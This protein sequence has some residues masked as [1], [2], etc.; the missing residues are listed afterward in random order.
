MPGPTRSQNTQVE[1]LV[2]A[3]L[4]QLGIVFETNAPDIAGKP[5]IVFR[6]QRAVVFVHGC[7]WH[8]H[9]CHLF[10]WPVK[11]PEFWRNKI[12]ATKIRD[13]AVALALT[14]DRWRVLEVWE[15]ALRGKERFPPDDVAATIHGWLEGTLDVAEIRGQGPRSAVRGG[16]GGDPRSMAG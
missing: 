5:D 1:M 2:T 15:C 10:H 13:A 8:G 12:G 9:D 6:D 16:S 4:A 7:F 14:T 11:R 3:A